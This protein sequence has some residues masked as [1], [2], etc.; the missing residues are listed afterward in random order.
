MKR[1]FLPALTCVFMLSSCSVW[2]NVTSKVTGNKKEKTSE[3][4]VAIVEQTSATA[5][6]EKTSQVEITDRNKVTTLPVK[7]QKPIIMLDSLAFM[8]LN[9]L[10][11]L[12]SIDGKILSAEKGDDESNRPFI[13]FDGRTRKF[14]AN[15]GCNTINGEYE[16][17]GSNGVII[18]PLLSTLMMCEFA[19]YQQQFKDALASTAT[20]NI[21]KE[22]G[23]SLLKLYNEKGSELMILSQPTIEFLNGAWG[24]KSIDGKPVD[25]PDLKIVIDVPEEK[26]HG[27]TGCNIFNGSIF[28]DPDKAGSIQFQGMAVTRMLCPDMSTE[29]AFLVALES[30]EFAKS[31][32]QNALLL[33]SSGKEVLVL[34]PLNL[35]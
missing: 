1:I 11:T 19:P 28:V 5:K 20:Y 12:R 31:N 27:N 29:T 16:T 15:D 32:G 2:N 8:K 22:E 7:G 21:S 24:V 25:N 34:I 18:N 30:V 23:E 35:Q 33:D 9:G 4:N 26:V 6:S 3:E 10:W 13:N 17:K 14:Y